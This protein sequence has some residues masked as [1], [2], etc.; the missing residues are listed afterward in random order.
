ME[1]NAATP[2]A[3][4]PIQRVGAVMMILTAATVL[5]QA[6]FIFGASD[7]RVLDLIKMS[8]RVQRDEARTGADSALMQLNG[9]R[10]LS[11]EEMDKKIEADRS[12]I[13]D[14]YRSDTRSTGL[15]KL[16]AGLLL[17]GVAVGV[18][19]RKPKPTRVIAGVTGLLCVIASINII[20]NLGQTLRF[21]PHE[22]GMLAILDGASC[23][24]IPL[25]A[26]FCFIA[27]S[28]LGW[29]R[30]SANPVR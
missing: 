23:A 6:A 12:A 22:N 8:A 5:G 16:L 13:I 2:P 24:L 9:Q 7:E 18:L 15:M 27:A 21:L 4:H 26:I 20:A 10:F 14:K 11:D 1:P 28:P 3:G 25:A 30:P 17:A 19:R 29:S